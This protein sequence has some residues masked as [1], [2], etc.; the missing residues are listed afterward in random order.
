MSISGFL[1]F[2][3][4]LL[5][6]LVVAPGLIK[7]IYDNY[8]DMLKEKTKVAVITIDKTLTEAEP[9]TEQLTKQFKNNDIKAIVLKIESGGGAA[10]TSQTIFNELKTLK[11]QYP[12][13]V[14]VFVEN[15]CASGAYYIACAA[16]SIITSP[17]AFIGS[18]GV[19]IPHPQL[20][21]FIEQF[22]IKYSVIKTGTFKAVGDPF[23]EDSA[24]QT[25]ML[26]ELTNAT[27]EQFVNDVA[28]SRSKLSRENAPAWAEGRV[29][30][31]SQ[32]LTLGLIDKTG[33]PS[34]VEQ[35]LRE[36]INVVGDIEWVKA[37]K[38]SQF[39]KFFSSFEAD[40]FASLIV[41]KLHQTP[42]LRMQ[43]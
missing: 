24:E 14:I 30:T 6:F 2:T 7:N 18:I 39:S 26:Q 33:S 22:K 10:G 3:L 20:K 41:E 27:Y 23:L 28:A 29:F 36:R 35:E 1:K 40:S 12:K 25:A 37:P 42:L 13:P 43:S 31:G 38:P 17:S 19:Y 5:V 15:I 11:Q 32:A 9:Y 8:Q 34:T 16:D 4:L 21:D